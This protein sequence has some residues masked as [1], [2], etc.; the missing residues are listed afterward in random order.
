MALRNEH[1][2]IDPENAIPSR[3]P[4]IATARLKREIANGVITDL[5]DLHAAL[6]SWEYRLVPQTV[7]DELEGRFA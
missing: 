7:R 1:Q 5:I 4:D 2:K 6:G 3:D